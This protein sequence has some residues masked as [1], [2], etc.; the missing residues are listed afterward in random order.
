MAMLVS[1]ASVRVA[2][3]VTTEAGASV[4]VFPKV[5]ADAHSD[6]VIQLTN[7]TNMAAQ[8]WC[9]YV[10]GGGT[11]TLSGTACLID[12]DCPVGE[13]CARQWTSRN[14]I[15]ALTMQQ[16]THWVVSRGRPVDPLDGAQGIDPGPVPP[17]PSASFRGEL[18]CVQVDDSQQPLAGNALVGEATLKDLSSGDVAKYTAIGM[19]SFLNNADRVLCLG[20]VPGPGCSTFDEFEG[21]PRSWRLDHLAYGAP[22]DQVGAGSAVRTD[23]TIVPCSHDFENQV[24]GTVTVLFRVTNEFE[25]VLSAATTVTC[26]LNTPLAA[27]SSAFDFAVLGTRYA[28]TTMRPAAGGA[29]GFLVVAQEFRDSGGAGT[30]SASS[31]LNAHLEGQLPGPDRIV[32]PVH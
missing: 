29:K 16:P 14:F 4:V 32:L 27:I 23:L 15:L 12:A 26:W 17:A 9:F 5:V 28:Q 6:T 11:C 30:V 22:D 3:Q 1:I 2:A 31:T 18:L 25:Q 13:T 19:L 8:V 20:S 7:V 10:E 24:P 21:C